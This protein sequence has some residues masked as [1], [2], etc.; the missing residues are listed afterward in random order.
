VIDVFPNFMPICPVRKFIVPVTKKTPM[1]LSPPFCAPLA[2][3]VKILTPDFM[4]AY[5]SL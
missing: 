1:H 4:S 3:S 2:Q 5:I